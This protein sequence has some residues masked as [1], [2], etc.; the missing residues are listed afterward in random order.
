[1]IEI[2]AAYLLV[3]T[4]FITFVSLAKNFSRKYLIH[5]ASWSLVFITLPISIHQLHLSNLQGIHP[6]ENNLFLLIVGLVVSITCLSFFL[7]IRQKQNSYSLIFSKKAVLF[8]TASFLIIYLIENYLLAG[9]LV[10]ITDGALALEIHSKTIPVLNLVSRSGFFVIF[11][12]LNSNLTLKTKLFLSLLVI[13]I[14]I[15]RGSRWESLSCIVSFCVC[16]GH[17]QNRSINS[18]LILLLFC[19]CFL[20]F[21][22][23]H[24]IRGDSGSYGYSYIKNM[25][26]QYAFLRNDVFALYYGYWIL[27]YENFLRAIYGVHNF[28]YGRFFLS[29]FSDLIFTTSDILSLYTNRN[30][31]SFENPVTTG[32]VSTLLLPIYL[33]FKL[34]TLVVVF[35][36]TLLWNASYYGMVKSSL[37]FLLYLNFTIGF[38]FFSF[39]P[40]LYSAGHW[41]RFIFLTI[42][43]L[44]L[45]KLKLVRLN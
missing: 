38:A 30:L 12:I 26:L 13:L 7:S 1:M 3:F 44:I 5:P 18:R 11:L 25:Q 19:M 40:L 45:K 41:R 6:P 39:M 32:G 17:C 24:Q 2:T 8:F 31:P 4:N 36:L 20:M 43:Y 10:I 42:I 14:S 33:D 37:V 27:P 23:V 16:V 35:I 15:S 21:E 28:E 9:R 22:M 29:I 34:G